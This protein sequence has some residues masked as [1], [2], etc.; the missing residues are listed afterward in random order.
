MMAGLIAIADQGRALASL[1]PLNSNGTSGGVDVH[2]LI[3]SLAG[4]A[5]SYAA[6]FHDITSGSN[7]AYSAKAG[8]DACTGWG[9]PNGANLLHE[10]GG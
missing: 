1:A 10:L 5:T 4:N 6:D 2:T 8:W 3:Y 9:T 7:G